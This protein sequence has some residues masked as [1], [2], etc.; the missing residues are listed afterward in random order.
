MAD[1]CSVQIIVCDILCL[2]VERGEDDF[3]CWISRFLCE[4]LSERYF[5]TS[6]IH[7]KTQMSK[8]RFA[9]PIP[10]IF[11]LRGFSADEPRA[12]V[13]INMCE[14][15]LGLQVPGRFIGPQRLYPGQGVCMSRGFVSFSGECDCVISVVRSVLRSDASANINITMRKYN[16]QSFVHLFNEF[17][18][19]SEQNFCVS[20]TLVLFSFVSAVMLV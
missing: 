2:G 11:H 20:L 5:L 10:F 18:S 16:W 19:I 7:G 12:S 14:S 3:L 9:T 15:D 6:E 17:Y 4:G 8:S 13:C 1:Q